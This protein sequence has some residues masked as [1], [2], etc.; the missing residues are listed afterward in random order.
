MTPQQE[1]VE[2]RLALVRAIFERDDYAGLANP[3]VGRL[4]AYRQ[5]HYGRQL[6][7]YTAKAAEL[8]ARVAV[9]EANPDWTPQ[10]IKLALTLVDGGCRDLDSIATVVAA[11]LGAAAP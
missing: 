6:D 7:H 2:D 9:R 5:E 11:V 8:T 1:L 3:V 10:Q 4:P